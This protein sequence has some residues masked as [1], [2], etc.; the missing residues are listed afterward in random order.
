MP[1]PFAGTLQR[2]PHQESADIEHA[3]AYLPLLFVGW[4][5]HARAITILAIALFMHQQRQAAPAS[6]DSPRTD[7]LPVYQQARRLCSSSS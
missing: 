1:A 3:P 5:R 6:R 7:S 2:R 4:M